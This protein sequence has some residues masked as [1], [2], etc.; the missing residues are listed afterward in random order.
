MPFP[1]NIKKVGN[2]GPA[3]PTAISLRN[4]EPAYARSTAPIRTPWVTA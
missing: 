4:V 3:H 1:C 2:F